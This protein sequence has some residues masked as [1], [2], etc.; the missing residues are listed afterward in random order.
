[1]NFAL[2][3][4]WHERQRYLPGILAVAFSAVLIALTCGLLLGLLSVTSIPITRTRADVWVGS[5]GVL[6]VDIA[7]I[8]PT[9]WY[10]RVMECPQ[11]A[12][13]EEY[14][15]GFTKWKKPNGADELCIVIGSRLDDGSLGAVEA[16]TPE[17]REKLTE[18]NAVV[19]DETEL[20][21]LGLTTGVGE[22]G[23]ILGRKVRVVGLIK[24][25][26]SLAGPYVFCSLSTARP[27]LRL[28]PDEAS[29]LLAKCYGPDDAATVARQLQS[30]HGDSMAAYASADFA[31]R[32]EWHWLTKTKAGVAMGVLSLLGLLVG[33]VVTGFTLYAATAASIREYAVLRALGIPRW[34]MG[35]AVMNQSFWVGVFGVAVGL[36][37]MYGLARAIGAAGNLRVSLA[38][39]LLVSVAV[40]TL[41]MALVSGLAALRILRQVEPAN[42]LR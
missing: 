34:R 38:P 33:A 14:C 8:V 1:M 22:T 16:L 39:W 36:P 24:G 35:L 42:L 29:Y 19:I 28:K 15:E 6:S 26:S 25:Y 37:T 3:T 21:R 41:S 27:L 23:E 10:S 31:W 5:A 32:S 2:A 18:P 4:L 13:C 9:S 7:G 12:S 40:V 20:A 17:L 11:V 30:R